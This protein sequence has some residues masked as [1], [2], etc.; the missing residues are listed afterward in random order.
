MNKL[1]ERDEALGAHFCAGA[2][3]NEEVHYSLSELNLIDQ[4]QEVFLPLSSTW[5]HGRLSGRGG[6]GLL[7]RLILPKQALYDLKRGIVVAAIGAPVVGPLE[8][9][10]VAPFLRLAHIKEP[11]EHL[12]GLLARGEPCVYELRGLRITR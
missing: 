4:A 5:L 11:R 1:E 8:L 12:K 7:D 6:L 3:V 9:L 2:Q 10:D